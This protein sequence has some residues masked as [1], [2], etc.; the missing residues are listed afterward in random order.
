MP[1]AAERLKHAVEVDFLAKLKEAFG[2]RLDAVVLYGSYVEGNF[3]P[4]TS[5]VNVL[6]LLSEPDPDALGRL[7]KS[8]GGM[9]RKRRITPL[10]LTSGEFARSSDVFPMEYLDIAARHTVLHGGD[11]T[12]TLAV[13]RRNLRHQLEHQ[14]R[15]NLISLR[16]LVLAARG[17]RRLL[18]RELKRW[19]GPVAAVFRGLLRLKGVDPVPTTPDA[20]ISSVND[21]FGLESGPF[22]E[23]VSYRNGESA[24][25]VRLA[26]AL[27]LRL[28]D[29]VETVDRMES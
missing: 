4:G 12:A 3:H 8:A 9:M 27:L 21:A 22:M 20:L 11:P 24:D 25:P 17:R 7:A 29:L 28:A 2:E 14:M 10:I 19:Y 1:S 16:Q 26:E 15:G 5:D 6:V 23:L 18:G 13:D